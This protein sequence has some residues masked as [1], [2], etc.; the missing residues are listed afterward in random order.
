M[1]LGLLKAQP[2]LGSETLPV[3]A[4]AAKSDEHREKRGQNIRGPFEVFGV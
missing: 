2:R 4:S 3:E 1:A